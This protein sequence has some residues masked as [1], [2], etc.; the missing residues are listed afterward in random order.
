M[1]QKT[2]LNGKKTPYS[3]SLK[4]PTAIL[5]NDRQQATGNRQQATGNRQQATGNRQQATGN[6]QL[7]QFIKFRVNYLTDILAALAETITVGYWQQVC[8]TNAPEPV[9]ALPEHIR[10]GKSPRKTAA[11]KK[12]YRAKATGNYTHLLINNV[13]YP[14]VKHSPQNTT[15]ERMAKPCVY[16]NQNVVAPINSSTTKNARTSLDVRQCA[17]FSHLANNPVGFIYIL[18]GGH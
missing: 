4:L 15:K 12:I 11:C 13:N 14:I 5:S 16:K 3:P 6:R 9:R 7:Y 8:P 18:S 2:A 17:I 10:H 1:S